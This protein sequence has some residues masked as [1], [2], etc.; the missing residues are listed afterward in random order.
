MKVGANV[1]GLML[2]KKSLLQCGKSLD[3]LDYEWIVWIGMED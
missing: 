1:M 3:S 2:L